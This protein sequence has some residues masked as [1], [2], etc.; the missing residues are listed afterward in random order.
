[1]NISI[2]KVGVEDID[3]LMQWRM[4]VLREVFTVPPAQSLCEL[5]KENRSYYL[6]ELES[7]GHIACFAYDGE[8]IIGCGGICIYRE[9][10]SPDNPTG[11]CA[12]LMNVF[13]APDFRKKGV[14]KA[15]V[16]WLTSQARSLG[17]TK[18]YLETS[19]AGRT[20][21]RNLGFEDMPDMMKL[22]SRRNYANY[23]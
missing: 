13:T 1:M 20:L 9:M 6:S 19:M 23:Q 11:K 7:G 12:Y 21:Y 17:I 15:V 8:K 5:E 10:P 4:T 2:R 16:E 14:G 22:K 18:I 3:E